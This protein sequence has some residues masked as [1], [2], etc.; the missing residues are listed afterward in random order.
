M[1]MD[2][3]VAIWGKP[4]GIHFDYGHAR[5]GKMN[6]TLHFGASRFEFVDDR[7]E[8]IS[9]HNATLPKAAF[10]D[11]LGFDSSPEQVLKRFGQPTETRGD[12]VSSQIL[13]FEENGT[14]IKFHFM[15]DRKTERM[16][17]IAIGLSRNVEPSR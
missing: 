7:L 4:S 15:K 16:E 17:P 11:G 13:E 10:E 3:V 1:N 9:I 2:E 6:V 8:E 5:R 14:E 12:G